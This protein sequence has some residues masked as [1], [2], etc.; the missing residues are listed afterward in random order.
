MSTAETTDPA[1]HVTEW[2]AAYLAGGLSPAERARFE[3]H[4]GVCEACAAAVAEM[5][6]RGRRPA[7]VVRPRAT[8][9]GIRGRRDRS[10]ET[11]GR[12]ARAA[13]AGHVRPS[14]PRPA[15]AGKLVGHVP[16]SLLH[17]MVRRAAAGVAAAVVL[18]AVGYAANRSL[19]NG[20]LPFMS[21]GPQ[22]ADGRWTR[23]G[24]EFAKSAADAP[25]R[26]SAV[27]VDRGQSMTV[28]DGERRSVALVDPAEL[29]RTTQ[30]RLLTDA[31]ASGPVGRPPVATQ[32]Q[33]VIPEATLATTDGRLGAKGVSE[34]GDKR[35]ETV[36]MFDEK[37]AAGYSKEEEARDVKTGWGR[38]AG[39]PQ[40]GPAAPAGGAV[41]GLA[42]GRS[43]PAPAGA[44]QSLSVK[45]TNNENRETAQGAAAR[46]QV[47]AGSGGAAT[48]GLS[49]PVDG[50]VNAPTVYLRGE[51][52]RTSGAPGG[53]VATAF[54]VEDLTKR[55]PDFKDAPNF[56]TNGGAVGGGG[57]GGFG[58]GTARGW[59]EAKLGKDGKPSG[60]AAL[61][62]SYTEGRGRLSEKEALLS[63]NALTDLKIPARSD[64]HAFKPGEMFKV[65]IVQKEA[66]GTRGMPALSTVAAPAAPGVS[67][68]AE[69]GPRA[70]SGRRA[71]G[72]SPLR[73]RCRGRPGRGRR[74]TP[75]TAPPRCPS[76]WSTRPSRRWRPRPVSRR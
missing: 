73:P 37:P 67:A 63:A 30:L 17:P 49:V 8:R 27:L 10:P 51:D 26:T 11:I 19:Q 9:R 71:G 25:A 44:S 15:G 40:D 6:R 36:R 2:I 41:A 38:V 7:Q 3:A 61:S 72:R 16:R 4:V 76:P 65:Q 5:E 60:D 57:M 48:W 32:E 62:Y 52:T 74:P 58:G 43:S 39:V 28:A 34:R 12:H 31:D 35:S 53:Q 54:D 59:S 13:G 75:R 55:T 68:P 64:P 50:T 56:N 1:A 29:G 69:D 24:G 66:E 14:G 47:A 45:P 20:S 22:V 33:T 42:T 23:G 70:A 21:N 18:G 46:T